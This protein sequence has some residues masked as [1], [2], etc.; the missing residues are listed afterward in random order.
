[1][2]LGNYGTFAGDRSIV[3]DVSVASAAPMS[4]S[5]FDGT[6]AAF[7]ES[8]DGTELFFVDRSTGS[9]VNTSGGGA[10]ITVTVVPEPSSI[11]LLGLSGLL[12]LRRRR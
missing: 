3:F 12:L 9:F 2:N 4:Y 10:A 11:S 7:L 5:D 1:M 6:E 8:L